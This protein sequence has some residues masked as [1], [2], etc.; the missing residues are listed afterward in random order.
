M[1]NIS[2]TCPSRKWMIRVA[3]KSKKSKKTK[4]K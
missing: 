1:V 4:K 2:L 3:K